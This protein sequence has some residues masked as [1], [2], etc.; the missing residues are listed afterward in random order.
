MLHI[1]FS[2][3]YVLDGQYYHIVR[4]LRC[5]RFEKVEFAVICASLLIVGEQTERLVRCVIGRSNNGKSGEASEGGEGFGDIC[6][7]FTGTGDGT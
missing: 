7:R 6:G 1:F 3:T 5:P 2:P 4:I